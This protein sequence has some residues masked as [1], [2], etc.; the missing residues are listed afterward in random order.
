MSL[1]LIMISTS[2]YAEIPK[3]VKKDPAGQVVI[4]NR[5]SGTISI[6]ESARAAVTKT[7]DLPSGTLTPEP[8]YVVHIAQSNT[9]FVGDRA[10]NRVVAF[11]DKNYKIVGTLPAGQG[12]FHMWADPAGEQLWINNDID[13]TATVIDPIEFE[14]LATVPMPADLVGLGAKPHDVIVDPSGDSAYVTLVGLPGT[15]DYVVKFSTETF[16]ELA[17]APVGKDPHLSL[18]KRSSYL[19]VPNQNS[20]SVYILERENLSKVKVIEVPGAH[21]AGMPRNGKVFYTTNISGGGS[22][23]VYAIDT[24]KLEVLASVDTPFPTPH[25]IAL[26]N[27][28]TDLY[29]THSGSTA[30]KVSI[31]RT[32]SKGKIVHTADITVG[33]NPFGLAYIP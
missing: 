24:K 8:M 15:S 2:L 3:P 5:N 14:I 18:S 26:S 27:M 28:G 9:V 4:A 7:V 30:D 13:N 25:N 19:F 1:T 16:K 12:V 17:R 10:N 6:I 32:N 21:G 20:N 11:D 22:D 23:G 31:Y 33:L 29:V